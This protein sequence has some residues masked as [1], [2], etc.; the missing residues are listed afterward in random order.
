MNTIIPDL[1]PPAR[2][3]VASC[4]RLDA[5]RLQSF[6]GIA[7]PL[8]E[9]NR[10]ALENRIASEHAAECLARV[11]GMPCYV[12]FDGLTGYNHVVVGDCLYQ[13]DAPDQ[14][15]VYSAPRG[16]PVGAFGTEYGEI[17]TN[18]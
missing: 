17:P 5:G 15:V 12:V 6:Q 18:G 2:P 1:P 13:W 8:Y 4:G 16:E 14:R 10:S 9:L 11:L 3:Q 7:H